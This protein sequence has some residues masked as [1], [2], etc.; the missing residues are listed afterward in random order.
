MSHDTLSVAGVGDCC[1][2]EVGNKRGGIATRS[3][4]DF[5]VEAFEP[6]SSLLRHGEQFDAKKPWAIAAYGRHRLKSGW[7]ALDSKGDFD[8]SEVEL[9]LRSSA[10]PLIVLAPGSGI[11]LYLRSAE[12][13]D[14]SV[15][16]AIWP[17]RQRFETFALRRLS[18]LEEAELVIAGFLRV[19][20]RPNALGILMQLARRFLARQALGARS[21][22]QRVRGH[23]RGARQE[24]TSSKELSGSAWKIV[25]CDNLVAT[26]REGDVLAPQA[27]DIVRAQF[28]ERP[29]IHA[30][31]ADIEEQGRVVPRPEWDPLLAHFYPYIDGP[32]FFRDVTKGDAWENLTRIAAKYGPS[33]ISRIAL[34]L[35]RRPYAHVEQLLSLPA[36]GLREEVF[37][38]LIIPTKFQIELL[39]RNLTALTE[40]TAYGNLEIIIVDNGCADPEFSSMIASFSQKIA[41]KCLQD[42]GEFNFSRL[43]NVGAAAASGEILLLLNDDV[44]AIEP[45]WLRRMV[46]SAIEPD[47]GAVGARLL[48]PD[49]TIQ[50]AGV[51][52]GIGG[53]A[54]HM[55]K[56]MTPAQVAHNP[57]VTYPGSR[58]AVTGACLAV[59]KDLFRRV[60]GFDEAL[61]VALNDIDFCLRIRE[62][63]YR[64]VYRG[65]AVLTHHE[66]RSRGMDDRTVS[67]RVRLASETRYFLERWPKEVLNDPY[68]SPAFDPTTESGAS[69]PSVLNWD[70]RT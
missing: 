33:A 46:A 43:I 62:L 34:P 8:P 50:H 70:K 3:R 10:D 59:R 29:E 5:L 18:A 68:G 69:Y 35:A 23:E 15:L 20:S 51:I 28:A 60:G 2:A 11:H 1:L 19:L 57:Y 31:F 36:P 45:T 56:G 54:G 30:I 12:L 7:W 52:L 67:T 16:I 24:A 32:A 40:R 6:G 42:L 41:V 17:R 63:G 53:V 21:A 64:N 58:M 47:V 48:Y 4:F 49:G 61:A 37:V 13:Y 39:R 14:I 25:E 9:R 44:E 38:S 55:W 65:D 22:A 27:F 26:V 66:G